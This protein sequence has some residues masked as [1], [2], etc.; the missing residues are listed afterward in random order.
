MYSTNRNAVIVGIVLVLGILILMFIAIRIE[1]PSV[2][3]D[4]YRL[5]TT[6]KNV[7]G[8]EMSNPVTISGVNAGT[9]VDI[10]YDSAT[11]TVS[12][13]M[14]VDE[15]YKVPRGS[16]ATIRSKS[17]LGNYYVDIMPG[18]I[19][20]GYLESG[21]ELESRDPTNINDLM[22]MAGRFSEEA[23]G[24]FESIRQNQEKLFGDLQAMVDENRENLKTATEALAS[25]G[26]KLDETMD[27]VRSVVQAL[28]KGE[29]TLGKMLKDPTVH[30]N[31]LAM[32]DALREMSEG[33]G[34]GEGTLGKL[35]QSDET[36]N[37]MQTTFEHADRAFVE[38]Q[39]AAG[40]MRTLFTDNEQR[41]GEA[42]DS[43]AQ[44]GP[45]LEK[46]LKNVEQI[47]M[48][49]NEGEGTI[50]KMVNDPDLYNDARNALRQ[51]QQAFEA[52]EEQSVVRTFLSV[53]VGS[54]M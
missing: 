26:P 27:E 14:A 22:E 33:L 37:R 15:P 12:V 21:A 40:D 9:V 42:L 50:G 36:Y 19:E 47:S 13:E 54:A 38:F 16:V 44:L 28:N 31:M 43:L 41:L 2:S 5:S 29:G 52:S 11:A 6:F 25:A 18:E 10:E 7:H 3:E 46:T 35:M 20:R 4:A 1:G 8:L 49:V 17:L 23:G 48:K 39:A 24:L 45:N 32:S 34:Q 53:F 51:I 30:D